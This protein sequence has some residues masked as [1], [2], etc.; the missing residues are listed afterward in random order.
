MNKYIFLVVVVKFFALSVM[1]QDTK[2]QDTLQSQN[3]P[4]VIVRAYEQNRTLNDIPAAVNYI[5]QEMLTRYNNTGILT[6]LNATAGVKMEERSPGSYRLNIRGS[7]L[8]APFGVRNVKIYYNNIPFTDPGGNTYLNQLG[9]YNFGSVEIIKG[10]GSSL[11]GAGTGGVMLIESNNVAK[12]RGAALSL[13]GGS[14]G[15]VNSNIN[16][17]TGNDTFSNVI[18]YQHQTGD[19]YRQQSKLR[20][21]VFSWETLGKI[22]Q[23]DKITGTFFYGDLYYQT[24]GALTLAEYNN[25]PKAARPAAGVSPGAKE[26]GAAIFQKMFLSA[27]SYQKKIS[28]TWQNTS[29]LYGAFTKLDNPAIRNYARNNQPQF[30]GRTVFQ[31]RKSL[32]DG[33]LLWH[34]GAEL[35]QGYS[36][37][38]IYRNKGGNPDSLQTDDEINVSTWFIF[39]QLSYQNKNWTFT[40]GASFNRSRL[41]FTRLSTVPANTYSIRFNNEVAPRLAVLRKI[42][43]DISAYASWSR[44]FSPP[45]ADEVFPT[46]SL[47]NPDLQAEQG[48]NYEAGV[49]GRLLKSRLSF[50]VSAFYF[51]LQNAIVQRRDA[52]GGDYYTNA[53]STRQKGIETQ[54]KYHLLRS[55]VSDKSASIW[56]SHTIYSFNYKDFKQVAN[57]FSGNRLPGIAKQSVAAGLDLRSAIGFYTNITYQY[58]DPV[59]LNDANSAYAE[60]YNLLSG[61]IGYKRT[62]KAINFDLFAGAENITDVKYSLGNDLNAFGGR[63]Y[64][65]ATGRNFFGG[66]TVGYNY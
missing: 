7:S 62:F 25:D 26:A 40:A 61:R 44:G 66:V 55:N 21:D 19:G 28:N 20:R 31:Y 9:F 27:V 17:K 45:T 12:E 51:T 8:R 4:E 5:N 13:S 64:N 34:T 48:I 18:N 29:T 37:A 14:Y 38:K 52:A 3:L 24:P 33:E 60:A 15:M 35:Q 56:V 11:Y 39:S 32:S 58:S 59:P 46:G 63:Y 54:I 10:P 30:G 49:K 47:A 50:D 36:T 16:I 1:G 6:A 42:N 57:D 22:N 2:V 23:T 65:A 43:R 41:Q 53:G